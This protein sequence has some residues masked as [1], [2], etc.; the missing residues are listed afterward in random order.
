M[1]KKA[2]DENKPMSGAMLKMRVKLTFQ[3]T[4]TAFDDDTK[5]LYRAN[6]AEQV[7]FW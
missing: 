3:R 7:C 1:T 6:M 5:Q 2:A 4:W